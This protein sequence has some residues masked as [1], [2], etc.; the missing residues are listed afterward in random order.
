M[1]TGTTKIASGL[2]W[3]SWLWL[4]V[5]RTPDND[6]SKPSR[7]EDAPDGRYHACLGRCLDAL[8]Q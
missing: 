2:L 6:A 1:R 8:R 3:S 4:G 7:A 5:D